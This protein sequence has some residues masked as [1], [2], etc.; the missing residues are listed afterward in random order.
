MNGYQTIKCCNFF[1][2]YI[3]HHTVV[4]HF[5]GGANWWQGGEIYVGGGNLGDKPGSLWVK[6]KAT[7]RC[8]ER[9]GGR[10]GM[11]WPR[12]LSAQQPGPGT[13]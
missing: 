10:D 6:I 1:A 9:K 13:R 8:R 11:Y 12:W 5:K 3:L 2:S 7:R 4:Y